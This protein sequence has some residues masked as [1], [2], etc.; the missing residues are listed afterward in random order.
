MMRALFIL[1]AC[2]LWPTPVAAQSVR[3]SNV[4]IGTF[5]VGQFGDI[6]TT[7]YGIG[8][9]QFS[10][11]N[12]LLR[13]AEH[14]PVAMAVT[15]GSLAVGVSVALLKARRSHPKATFWTAVALTAVQV[16]VT[17]HNSRQL[18]GVRQ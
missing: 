4:A 17:W 16:G 12:P 2:L 3:A 9:G 5:M 13:W 10:E 14:R 8:A 15:K 1:L 6:T 7:A 11:A 18:R